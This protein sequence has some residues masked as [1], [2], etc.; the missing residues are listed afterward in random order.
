[1]MPVTI[2][3]VYM[4][5]SR[6]KK[7]FGVYQKEI[8]L[9]N[10]VL[11]RK[12]ESLESLVTFSEQQREKLKKAVLLKERLISV[13]SHDI[14]VPL[15]SFKLLINNFEKGYMSE[16]MVI[17]GMIETKNDL[18]QIDKMVIDLVNWSRT[19]NAEKATTFAVLCLLNI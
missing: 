10:E 2:Q 9:Q 1:M 7:E 3:V 19:G 18:T 11:K 16:A 8:K 14:R 6:I 12:N 4:I 17:N 13:I 15:S 5:F